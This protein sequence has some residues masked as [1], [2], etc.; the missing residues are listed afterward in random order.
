MQKKKSDKLINLKILEIKLKRTLEMNNKLNE[1]L[2][3]N[4]IQASNACSL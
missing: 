3:R 2:I 4:R 1:S